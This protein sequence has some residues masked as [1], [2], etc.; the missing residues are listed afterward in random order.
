MLGR[1]PRPAGPRGARGGLQSAGHQGHRP[2][3]GQDRQG[4]CPR[5]WRSCL[6]CDFLPEVWH[7]DT[8]TQQL[9]ELTGRRAALV[10]QR[11][12]MRNRIHSV[13]AMRL[14]EAPES[15]FDAAG[16][17]WLAKLLPSLDAQGQLLISSDLRLLQAVQQEI[18]T[19]GQQLAEQGWQDQRVRLLM[20][21]P[22][23]DV[24]VAEAVLAALGDIERFPTPE[25]AAAYLGLV[26]STRQSA[27]KCYHGPITKRGNNQARWML[28]QAAQHIGKHPGPLGH[29]FRRLKQRKN[30]NVAVVATARKLV[31]IAWHMLRKN[32]PY[33]YA[34]P[35]TTET[36]LAKL[37]VQATGE[38]AE[39]MPGQGN[40]TYREAARWQPHHQIPGSRVRQ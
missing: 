34:I 17:D 25:Q 9:R 22:G 40:Q 1:G 7:P 38:I 37:R 8:T 35:R 16:Q 30:H 19:L 27:D 23:V 29:F 10:Q 6:R 26:P 33:R 39:E 2:G 11:T 28:I 21:L 31:M 12:A 20:T 15:L 18:E 3:E 13:L 14:I 24:T 5:A 4:R 32:E 36:K